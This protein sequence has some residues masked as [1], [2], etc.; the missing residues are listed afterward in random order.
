MIISILLPDLRC[1]GA[2]RVMLD[3]AHEFVRAGHEVEFVCMQARGEFLGEARQSFSLVDLATPRA[4]HLPLALTRYLRRRRPVSLLAAMWP[5]TGI[6]GVATRLA[7]RDIRLVSSEHVD[8][9]HTPSLRQS[10]RWALKRFGQQL[11]APCHSVV[12]VSQGV[13]DSLQ[14][15][16][17]LSVERLTVIHNPVRPLPPGLMTAE[18]RRHLAGWLEG[19]MRLIAI[20]TLKRQKGYDVLLRALADLRKRQDARL[21]ILGEGQLR[22]E[23]ERLAVNLGIADGVWMP[24]FRANPGTFLQHADVFV[25]SSNWEGFG[26]VIVEALAAGVAIVST[27][28]P[29][30]PAEILDNGRYGHLVPPADAMA[31]SRAIARMLDAPMPPDLL[32]ARARS[33]RPPDKA[34]Q[35]LRLLTGDQN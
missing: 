24:G 25:M 4:R 8:F 2:E 12:A 9:R 26:N 29:S 18:D 16:A 21:L 31:L 28:C 23:L 7:G 22:D 10:E 1:G 6:A 17:G 14:E 34:A 19:G 30:G 15:V 35:Y 5:L 11:Y 32:K 27:D 20:G 3:L 13:A 33:F